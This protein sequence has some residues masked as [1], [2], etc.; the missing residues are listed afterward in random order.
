MTNIVITIFSLTVRCRGK[1]KGIEAAVLGVLGNFFTYSLVNI[2][3]VRLCG[4]AVSLR[5]AFTGSVSFLITNR[6]TVSLKVRTEFILNSAFSPITP[7]SGNLFSL[8][9]LVTFTC[10]M[11]G[12]FFR[13]VGHNNVLLIR[14][15][16]KSLCV[17]DMP[18]NCSS[19]FIR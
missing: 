14:V 16:I 11:V 6:R 7:N 1:Q 13:G 8:L 4:F 19:N 10:Y 17:F 5:G 9:I 2:I 18:E 3:P 12:V 15:S